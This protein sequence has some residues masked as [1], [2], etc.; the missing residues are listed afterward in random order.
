MT[1]LT[2]DGPVSWDYDALL[3]AKSQL[4]KSEGIKVKSLPDFLFDFQSHL[5]ELAL[6]HGRFAIL[7]DCGLGKSPVRLRFRIKL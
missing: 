1:E 7:A 6:A 2:I 5:V 3:R 4:G